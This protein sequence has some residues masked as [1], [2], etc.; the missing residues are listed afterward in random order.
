MET[1]KRVNHGDGMYGITPRAEIKGLTICDNGAGTVWIELADGE[2]GEF[3]AVE[4]E[5]VLREFYNLNF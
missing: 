5:K 3:R 4:V 2:G 1:K